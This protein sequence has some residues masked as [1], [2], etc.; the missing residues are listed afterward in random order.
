MVIQNGKKD[1]IPLKKH[2][3]KARKGSSW[4]PAAII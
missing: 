2:F 1:N 3:F 4:L